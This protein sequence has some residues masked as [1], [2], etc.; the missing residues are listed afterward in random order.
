MRWWMRYSGSRLL[1]TRNR[2]ESWKVT[3]YTLLPRVLHWFND[4][5]RQHLSTNNT[6]DDL[7]FTIIQQQT[8]RRNQLMDQPD[9]NSLTA[10]PTEREQVR[11]C[12]I[13]N[14]CTERWEEKRIQRTAWILSHVVR[15]T[16]CEHVNGLCPARWLNEQSITTHWFQSVRIC[17][18]GW[19][20]GRNTTKGQQERSHVMITL[21]CLGLP[22][23]IYFSASFDINLWWLSHHFAMLWYL[24]HY[25][26]VDS[27][28]TEIWF[29]SKYIMPQYKTKYKFFFW[30]FFI[31][32]QCHTH[33]WHNLL[34]SYKWLWI[35]LKN[36][37]CFFSV[38][39]GIKW[40]L[41]LYSFHKRKRNFSYR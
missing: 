6:D 16:L 4:A 14:T 25:T 23:I 9:D 40:K 18:Y 7:S 30:N 13:V 20:T 34:E 3:L 27:I 5:K 1:E 41:E 19:A 11:F 39:A 15:K 38:G 8:Y 24:Y 33:V 32:H 29:T 2:Q 10:L 36:W 12:E 28:W 22:G 21:C 26:V 17:P 31:T 37:T 35:H